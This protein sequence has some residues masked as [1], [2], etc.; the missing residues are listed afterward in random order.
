MGTFALVLV[1]IIASLLLAHRVSVPENRR[2]SFWL[3]L[4]AWILLFPL[5]VLMN[6]W[7]PFNSG[8]SD[9]WDYYYSAGTLRTWSDLVD[10]AVISRHFAQPGYNVVLNALNLVFSPSLLGFKSFNFF[11]FLLLILT[12]AN[13]VALL[14]RS[15]L[16]RSFALA[17]LFLTPLWFYFFFLLKDMLIAL[18]WAVFINGLLRVYQDMRSWKGW[19]LAFF[20]VVAFIPLRVPLVVQAV[21]VLLLV[22]VARSFSSGSLTRKSL[23]MLAGIFAAAVIIWFARDPATIAAFG[24]TSNTHTLATPELTMRAEVTMESSSINWKLFPALYILSETSG[25]NPATWQ[26][27]D[28]GWLRGLLALPWIFLYVPLLPAG[29]IWLLRRASQERRARFRMT[30]T[31]LV[32]T[33]WVVVAAF[34]ATSVAVSFASGDTTRWRISDM[35]A[36]LTVAVAGW[37]SLPKRKA[38]RLVLLWLLAVGS[39]FMLYMLLIKS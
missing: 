37:D 12:W 33:P 6:G 24:V 31:R 16:S 36:L 5:L 10:S 27:L 38:F 28:D 17:C 14:G 19:L 11:C 20:A 35:P 2:F 1:E 25:L 18:L 8:G 30:E 23:T 13:S 34:I 4:G 15:G 9:D 7:I 29:A 21:V 26:V 32:A 3:V 22:A 39:L